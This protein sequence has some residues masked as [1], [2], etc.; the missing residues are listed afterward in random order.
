M[1]NNKELIVINAIP[2]NQQKINML[3]DQIFYFKKLELPIMVVSGCPIPPHITEQIDYSIV[4]TDNEVIEKDYSHKMYSMGLYDLSYD[5]DELHDSI[6]FFYWKNVNSTITKNIKLAFNTAKILGYERVLY[7]E[8]DNIFKDGS[9]DY[10]N[11]N[12]NALR[13]GNYKMAG[14]VG[15]LYQDMP[16][17][18]TAF[19]FA[20]VKWFVDNFT[21]PHMKDEWYGY[22]TTV[23]YHLHRPYEYVFYKLF[24][25]KLDYFYDSVESYRELEQR[26]TNSTLMEFG[27]SNRRFNEKNLID[28]FFTVLPINNDSE[29]KKVLFLSNKSSYLPKGEKDYHVS[30][31]IN[32]VFHKD[33]IIPPNNWYRE[34]IS[35]EVDTIKLSISGYGYKTIDCDYSSINNNGHI[36][37]L[38]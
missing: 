1:K 31:F 5:F 23:K 10:L 26:N 20:D 25:K 7:T 16:M 36:I 29:R 21:L 27:K 19:F 33:V 18:C 15:E 28:T 22:N 34:Y 32:H 35:N 17:M 14:W 12:M 30:I 11:E 4:N 9:F 38:K 13:N 8:D 3:E 37:F 6:C 24:E 2:N